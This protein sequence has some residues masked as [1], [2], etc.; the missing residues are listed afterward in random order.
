M[1]LSLFPIVLSTALACSHIA[2]LSN[3]HCA[4]LSNELQ[5][6]YCNKLAVTS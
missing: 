6:S 3:G 4:T 1:I 5:L 2:G